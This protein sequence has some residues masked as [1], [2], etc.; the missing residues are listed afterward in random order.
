MIEAGGAH[1][2]E[3]LK[4]VLLGEHRP[5]PASLLHLEPIR[6]QLSI[7]DSLIP[8]LKETGT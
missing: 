2:F 5:H 8:Q 4:D 3:D 7:Y 1:P 6:P